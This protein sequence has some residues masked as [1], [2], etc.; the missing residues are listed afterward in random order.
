MADF[1]RYSLI[2]LL[3][4]AVPASSLGEDR[5]P[6]VDELDEVYRA[7]YNAGYIAGYDAAPGAS[8]LRQC[9]MLL[10]MQI[11]S[12]RACKAHMDCLDELAVAVHGGDAYLRAVAN[13]CVA[14]LR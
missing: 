9:E 14:G 1:S 3:A 12:Q 7:G 6:S 10:N 5:R 2:T 13:R 4:L 11:S 8:R